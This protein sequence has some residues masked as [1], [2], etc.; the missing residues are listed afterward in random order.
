MAFIKDEKSACFCIREKQSTSGQPT[1]GTALTVNW[2][3][4]DGTSVTCSAVVTS[5]R[6]SRETKR[7]S[8]FKYKLQFDDGDVRTTRR[9][10]LLVPSA[11]AACDSQVAEPGV[12]RLLGAEGG[13]SARLAKKSRLSPSAKLQPRNKHNAP[14]EEPVAAP[15]GWCDVCKKDFQSCVALAEHCRGKKHAAALRRAPKNEQQLV[16]NAAESHG[17]AIASQHGRAKSRDGD[18]INGS[19]WKG[20]ST[21]SH[22]P[23]D[24]DVNDHCETPVEAYQDIVPLLH[25]LASHSR[26]TNAERRSFTAHTTARQR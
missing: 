21:T 14:R 5:I 25:R 15:P 1:A 6:K 17:G 12:K 22:H 20:A 11:K 7:G 3:L 18:A 4:E 13:S 24:V 8:S 10:D 26:K 16:K 19:E 23:F 2:P 9:L